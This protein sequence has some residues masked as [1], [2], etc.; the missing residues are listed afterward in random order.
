M[1]STEPREN[2]AVYIQAYD[3]SSETASNWICF[4]VGFDST[5]SDLCEQFCS[6]ARVRR[7]SENYSTILLDQNQCMTTELT[8]DKFSFETNDPRA[9]P[10]VQ[11]L[12]SE[13]EDY[14]EN[15]DVSGSFRIRP[16]TSKLQAL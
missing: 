7:N 3:R 5:I 4:N 8:E 13:K 6:I 2:H 12:S 1:L 15:F 9:C 11:V 16:T 10:L 14:V